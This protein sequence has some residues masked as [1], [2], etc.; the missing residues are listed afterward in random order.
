MNLCRFMTIFVSVL[1]SE[2]NGV[3]FIKLVYHDFQFCYYQMEDYL[4]YANQLTRGKIFSILL[5]SPQGISVIF[6]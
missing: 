6:Q 3:S 4:Y 5:Q 1:Y 2:E